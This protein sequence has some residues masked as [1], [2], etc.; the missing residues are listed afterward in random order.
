MKRS[1]QVGLVVGALGVAGMGGLYLMLRQDPCRNVA[2][3]PVTGDAAAD[4]QPSSSSGRASS[5]GS[6]GSSSHFGS[7]DSSRGSTPSSSTSE[8]ARGGFGS[9]GHAFSGG[10]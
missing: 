5:S 10:S 7:S 1:A 9:I 4:C 3:P 6:S 2:Q 8:A